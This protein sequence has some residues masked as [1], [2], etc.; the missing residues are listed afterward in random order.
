MI[1]S[2]RAGTGDMAARPL[3]GIGHGCG[4]AQVSM[5]ATCPRPRQRGGDD[6]PV[7]WADW[8]VLGQKVSVSF[9]FYFVISVLFFSRGKNVQ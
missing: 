1:H 5:W 3:D 4:D 8:A 7:G 6:E 9:L 2:L